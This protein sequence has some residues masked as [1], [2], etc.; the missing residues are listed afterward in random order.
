MDDKVKPAVEADF[1]GRIAYGIST[2][3]LATQVR[4]AIFRLVGGYSVSIIKK[5]VLDDRQRHRVG[6]GKKKI[7]ETAACEVRHR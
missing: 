1:I 2:A 4:G 6:G 5:A 3:P 7:A